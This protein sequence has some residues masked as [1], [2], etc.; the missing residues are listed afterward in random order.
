MGVGF[1][2]SHSNVIHL[3]RSGLTLPPRTAA[4]LA[5]WRISKDKTKQGLFA[6][7]IPNW[8]QLFISYI[9]VEM[10]NQAKNDKKRESSEAGRLGGKVNG[11]SVLDERFTR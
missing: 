1:I 2:L 6:V 7:A 3:C 11:T 8:R 4:G 5:S 10:R 9:Q